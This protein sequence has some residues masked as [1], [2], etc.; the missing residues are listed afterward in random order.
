ME[1]PDLMTSQEVA[2]LFAV[3]AR[4]VLA[5]VKKGRLSLALK[6]PGGH[7][8]FYRKE[9]ERLWRESLLEQ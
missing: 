8:R 2:D 6:T 7:V 3:T 5:W 4:T 9:V 1:S